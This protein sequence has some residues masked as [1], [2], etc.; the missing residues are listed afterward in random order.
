MKTY[1]L[2]RPAIVGLLLSV[3]VAPGA[4]TAPPGPL[5]TGTP[6]RLGFSAERLG[7]LHRR[8]QQFVDEGQHAGI[9]TLIARRGEIVDWRAWGHRD[10]EAKLPMQNDTIA[11]VYSMT[12]IVTSAAILQLH[13]QAR[14]RLDDPVERYLPALAK[15]QVLTGGTAETPELAPATRSITIKDLLTHT[16]GYTY[17]TGGKSVIDQLYQKADVLSATTMERFIERLS[18][19]PLVHEPGA[20]FTYGVSTDVIGAI[21]EQVS[22]QRLDRYVAEHLAGPLRMIDTAFVVPVEKRERL[23]RVYRAP[24]GGPLEVVPDRE[25][26][27]SSVD[28]V[29][30]HWG[31]AG[32]FSTLGD[33]A[34]F[35]QM[36]LNGGELDGVRVLGRK[37]VELML[38]NALTHTPTPYRQA[39][40]YEGFGLGGAVRLDSGRAARLGSVGQFGWSGA[41]NTYFNIDPQESTVVVLFAQHM[42]M[43]QFRLSSTFSTLFYAS[44][45]DAPGGQAKPPE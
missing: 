1:R 27:M 7:R 41:A 29:E 25:L 28:P 13:E 10:R 17:P 38:T 30:M 31:G 36:L 3:V 37:S 22:G 2:T 24:K 33:F 26:V 20:R 35:G 18:R 15:R 23:A 45:V 9:A 21:V 12:K 4:G 19:V 6:D 11:R 8:M 16:S 32:L 34:R 39:D 44:L 5:P 43:D 14:L 42:P 40:G